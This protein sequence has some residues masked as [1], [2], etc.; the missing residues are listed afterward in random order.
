MCFQC[1]TGVPHAC[2]EAGGMIVGNPSR[3]F[4]ADDPERSFGKRYHEPVP[5]PAADT[6]FRP[7]NRRGGDISLE[8]RVP[9]RTQPRESRG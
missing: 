3:G 6:V 5:R 1:D 7:V 4:L 8:P 9:A 2:P